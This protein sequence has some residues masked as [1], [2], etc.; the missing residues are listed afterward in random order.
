MLQRTC[1]CIVQPIHF[2][3]E[4]TGCAD[5][6]VLCTV[7]VLLHTYG[8]A[9]LPYSQS[10]CK[11]SRLLLWQPCSQWITLQLDS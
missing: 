8:H 9:T 5:A 11:R 2:T 3:N 10:S 1:M 4:S 7:K 6:L